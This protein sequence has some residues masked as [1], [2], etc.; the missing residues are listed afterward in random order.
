MKKNQFVSSRWR[1]PASFFY[2]PSSPELNPPLEDS[3]LQGFGLWVEGLR[4]LLGSVKN[5]TARLAAS[6]ACRLK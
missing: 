1:I 6:K 2:D 5:P 3:G 4:G